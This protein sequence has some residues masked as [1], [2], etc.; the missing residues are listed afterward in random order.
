MAK[1][2]GRQEV[3]DVQLIATFAHRG[4][5]CIFILLMNFTVGATTCRPPT[6]SMKE[7]MKV[8][9]IYGV[10]NHNYDQHTFVNKLVS[11]AFK[12]LKKEECDNISHLYIYFP[13]FF[14]FYILKPIK[15]IT[16]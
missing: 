3:Y 12:N 2:D 14:I 4:M 6:S 13:Q 1:T 8:F 15:K 10:G 16:L 11:H 5:D 7:G 9:M